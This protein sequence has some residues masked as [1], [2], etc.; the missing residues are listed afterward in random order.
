MFYET[1][2]W[3]VM[4]CFLSL[5]HLHTVWEMNSWMSG[6]R[7]MRLQNSG[8]RKPP[9]F[10]KFVHLESFQFFNSQ[11]YHQRSFTT[12]RVA[13]RTMASSE[14]ESPS[15][16][17]ACIQGCMNPD[18]VHQSLLSINH[19]ST[20]RPHTK[21]TTLFF[22]LLLFCVHP[23]EFIDVKGKCCRRADRQ[24]KHTPLTDYNPC[25]TRYSS[26]VYIYTCVCQPP[27]RI[28][29]FSN[30]IVILEN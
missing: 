14:V 28:T 24:D 16:F 7:A 29:L 6:V 19:H 5:L 13:F 8:T 21:K 2:K 4:C 23:S 26:V 10:P 3:M 27:S 25:G 15:I 30:S 20:I 9:L 12:S 11:R 1:T 22:F 17:V 18:F